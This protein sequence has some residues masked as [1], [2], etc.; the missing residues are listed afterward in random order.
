MLNSDI[1]GHDEADAAPMSVHQE[2]SADVA[3]GVLDAPAVQSRG[4]SLAMLLLLALRE[5]MP[6]FLRNADD[7]PIVY[8]DAGRGQAMDPAVANSV[9]FLPLRF[10]GAEPGDPWPAI[11]QVQDLLSDVYDHHLPYAEIVRHICPE[12]ATDV[13]AH[14]LNSLTRLLRAMSQH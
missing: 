9:D 4:A 6:A 13:V 10:A 5:I 14:W 12:R 8:A 11:R 2:L 1:C 7:S 3:F